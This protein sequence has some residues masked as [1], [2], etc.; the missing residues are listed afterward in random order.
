VAS[1]AGVRHIEAERT[2]HCE[3]NAS[4][5]HANSAVPLDAWIARKTRAGRKRASSRDHHVIRGHAPASISF[6]SFAS[7]WVGVR[8]IRRP[9]LSSS[10]A[11][12]S[13]G[14]RLRLTPAGQV[15][16]FT[17]RAPPGAR[18]L[19]R[20]ISS[21][22]ATRRDAGDL[23]SHIPSRTTAGDW[24][25]LLLLLLILVMMLLKLQRISHDI[26]DDGSQSVVV[27]R[28]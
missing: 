15:A 24:S 9:T 22:A 13:S 12:R 21:A 11:G 3:S 19:A 27:W 10:A 20:L 25:G 17:G 7:S 26:S 5:P 4:W 28:D 23:I 14:G 2:Q 1:S 16:A 8:R 6:C 18:G